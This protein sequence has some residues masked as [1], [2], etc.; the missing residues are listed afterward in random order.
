M[1]RIYR[2]SGK[3]LLY[4]VTGLEPGVTVTD[5]RFAVKKHPDV[6]DA[7]GLVVAAVSVTNGSGYADVEFR[8]SAEQT[9][10]LEEGDYLCGV[11]IRTSTG[12]VAMVDATLEPVEVMPPFIEWT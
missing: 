7:D 11:K 3:T 12:A 1:L 5:A 8:L 2:K 6:A 9:A 4:R 10:A